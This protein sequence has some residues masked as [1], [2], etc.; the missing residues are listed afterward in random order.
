M[1]RT[2]YQKARCLMNARKARRRFT[3]EF[4]EDAVLLV[5]EKGYS[6]AEVGRRFGVSENNANRWVRQ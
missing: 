5:V 6:S 2:N 1:L 3:Q 4:K